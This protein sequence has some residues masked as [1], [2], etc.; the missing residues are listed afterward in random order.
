MQNKNSEELYFRLI[1][2][3]NLEN[4]PLKILSA[5]NSQHKTPKQIKNEAV[6]HLA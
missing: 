3:P 2:K 4:S 5:T 6:G 1:A